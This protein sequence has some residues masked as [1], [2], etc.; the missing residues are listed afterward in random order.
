MHR[1]STHR[2]SFSPQAY[3]F[4]SEFEGRV[5]IKKIDMAKIKQKQ[6]KDY[7]VCNT[8]IFF[9]RSLFVQAIICIMRSIYTRPWFHACIVRC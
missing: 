4:F 7:Y 5:K 1:E 6:N 9:K 3:H 2:I 8:S